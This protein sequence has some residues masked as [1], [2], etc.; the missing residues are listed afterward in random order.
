[1]KN[2][3]LGMIIFLSLS[4]YNYYS[5]VLHYLIKPEQLHPQHQLNFVKLGSTNEYTKRERE[6][7]ISNR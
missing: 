6:R 3:F 7:K 4:L 1:M 5:Y 2:V